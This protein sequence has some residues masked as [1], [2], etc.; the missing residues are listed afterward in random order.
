[1]AGSGFDNAS[2]SA[3][4]GQIAKLRA[5]YE[6]QARQGLAAAGKLVL[7]E[8]NAH[9]PH[10]DGDFERTG[11]VTVDDGRLV[12]AVSYKDVAFKDQ[13]V[14]LHEDDELTHDAGRT[15]HF[16]E[17]AFAKSAPQVAAVLGDRVRNGMG[18]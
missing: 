13:A 14:V 9:V 3:F 5:G 4:V 1:M 8:S 2:V 7:A 17:R 10:E 16:L 15:A 18:G 12:A 11:R 6:K